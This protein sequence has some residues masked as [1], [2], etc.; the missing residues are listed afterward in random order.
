MGDL[1][2]GQEKFQQYVERCKELGV[3]D[4][5]IISVKDVVV[6]EEWVRFK[7]QFGCEEYG[8][9]LTC[10]PHLPGFSEC[11]NTVLCYNSGI[12]LKFTETET[13]NTMEKYNNYKNKLRKI[14]ARLER[15]IFLEGYHKVISLHSGPCTLCETCVIQGKQ[16]EGIPKCRKY[17]VSRPAMEAMGIS[18]FDT[19]RNVGWETKILNSFHDI[20]TYYGLL[21]IE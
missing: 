11:K 10:P 6:M 12:L 20:H 17:K 19:V 13:N 3:Q 8:Q 5:K 1:R 18:V 7:C 15:Q 14:M 21:L 9:H 2:V 4:A 16:I